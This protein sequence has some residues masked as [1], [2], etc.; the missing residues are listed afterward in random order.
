MLKIGTLLIAVAL[1]VQAPV[2]ENISQQPSIAANQQNAAQTERGTQQSPLFVKITSSEYPQPDPTQDDAKRLTDLTGDLAHYTKDLFIATVVL[3]LVTAGLL[4]LGM[5]QL[6]DNKR[7]ITAAENAAKAAAAQVKLGRDEFSATFRPRLKVRHVSLGTPGIP[8]TSS[9]GI[10]DK[11]V[12]SLVVVNGGSTKAT[13]IDSRYLIF[14]SV[15]REGLP[16]LSP[17]DDSWDALIQA[18]TVLESGESCSF[19]IN[20]TVRSDRQTSGTFI[21]ITPDAY[22]VYVMGQI[23]YRDE[24]GNERFMGF[25]RRWLGESTFESVSYSDYEYGD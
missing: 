16:M 21:R 25:C 10:G 19:E 12:G 22:A 24:S 2:S 15:A 6:K 8:F 4:I 1:S 5:F 3:A 13:V 7:S 9:P 20:G 11:I 23:Q 14:F 18:G 17:M